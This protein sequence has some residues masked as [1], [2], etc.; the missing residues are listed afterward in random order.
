[1]RARTLP[2]HRLNNLMA[3]IMGAAELG[4]AADEREAAQSELATIVR[5]AEEGS[6][7]LAELAPPSPR[8]R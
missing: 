5:L 3:K 6:M 7:L 1:L 2:L 8:S 4:L